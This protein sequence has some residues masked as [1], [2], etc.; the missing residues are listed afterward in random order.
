MKEETF[1]DPLYD[2]KYEE[3]IAKI[4]EDKAR[5]EALKKG[6]SKEEAELK[7]REAYLQKRREKLKEFLKKM[8]EKLA[9]LPN[10]DIANLLLSLIA[11]GLDIEDEEELEYWLK[12]LELE[13]LN[14]IMQY[15]Q[16]KSQCVNRE[17]FAK[18]FSPQEMA[19]YEKISRGIDI[20]YARKYQN[21]KSEKEFQQMKKALEKAHKIIKKDVD[22]Q[23]KYFQKQKTSGR[24]EKIDWEALMK[25]KLEENGVS[26]ES[27]YFKE[28]MQNFASS[29]NQAKF[30]MDWQ[31]NPLKRDTE[32]LAK[33][34]GSQDKQ[35]QNERVDNK[36]RQNQRIRQNTRGERTR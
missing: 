15:F 30:Y 13:G 16:I 27:D 9:S 36:E 23:V 14:R 1:T 3:E 29:S 22:F 17:T 10:Q 6:L 2:E 34:R 5:K 18:R 35:K 12:K 8:E 28:T 32:R 11:L 31:V 21:A 19:A 25:Q 24:D 33:L 26:S 20:A 4:F 7:A